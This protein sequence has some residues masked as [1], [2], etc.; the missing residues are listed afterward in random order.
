M[1]V[2]QDDK[3]NAENDPVAAGTADNELI[4]AYG[5]GDEYAFELLYNRYRRQL[6]GFLNNLITDHSEADEVFEETWLRV[7]ERLSAYRDEGRFSAW[8]FR[9]AHNIF[10]DRVR[11]KQNLVEL[12]NEEAEKIAVSGGS[13]PGNLLHSADLA[14]VIREALRSLPGDQK[15]VFILRQHDLSFKE[16]AEIQGCSI[17]TA[18]SRMQYALKNLRRY[19]QDVDHGDLL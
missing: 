9:I 17:N 5:R 7:I 8:L 2:I 15:E 1:N 4:E 3:P 12:D 6:Y 16:I 14:E 19:L 13:D 18:L 10:I 11:R